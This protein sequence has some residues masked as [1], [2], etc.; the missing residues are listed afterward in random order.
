MDF[1]PGETRYTLQSDFYKDFEEKNPFIVLLLVC[2]SFGLYMISWMYSVNKELRKIDENAPEPTRGALLLLI[3]PLGWYA[4]SLVITSLYTAN[5]LPFFATIIVPLAWI[6][7]YLLLL[8]YLY[9]FCT[10]FNKMTKSPASIW[11]VFLII[12]FLGLFGI[13]AGID[14]LLPFSA[15]LIICV[16][17]MQAEMNNHFRRFRIKKRTSTFYGAN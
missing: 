8:K 1:R 5:I 11:F 4:I 12:G 6:V 3:F 10:S 17:A 14:R 15:L 16:P 2:V 13:A 7:L 9:D